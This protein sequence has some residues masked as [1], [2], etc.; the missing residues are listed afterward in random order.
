MLRK[1]ARA[2]PPVVALTDVSRQCTIPAAT[3]QKRLVTSIPRA[4]GG[5][6]WPS[7]TEGM[8]ELTAQMRQPLRGAIFRSCAVGPIGRPITTQV[9]N[10][11]IGLLRSETE[12]ADQFKPHRLFFFVQ[13]L[14]LGVS[15]CGLVNS[16]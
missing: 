11:P 10:P 16:E 6:A 5:F 4:D 7:T 1:V 14:E 8:T 13:F 9:V 3:P 15:L 12:S 2:S